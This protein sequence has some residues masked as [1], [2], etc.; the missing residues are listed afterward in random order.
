MTTIQQLL[1]EGQ[2]MLDTPP[3]D[4]PIEPLS[5]RILE[6]MKINFQMINILKKKIT[7]MR[8]I[9][10]EKEEKNKRLREENGNLKTATN[11]LY[12]GVE[13]NKL[14]EKLRED[15]EWANECQLEEIKEL[16]VKLNKENWKYNLETGKL[17]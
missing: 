17:D 1:K 7:K 13:E 6:H 4:T 10:D 2:Q 15:L 14:N 9:Y 5:E 3:I 8:R 16:K 11:I 12:W